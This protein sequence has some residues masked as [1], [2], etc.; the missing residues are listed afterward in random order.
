MSKKIMLSEDSLDAVNGG[1]NATSNGNVNVRAEPSLSAM[2]LATVPKGTAFNT[3]GRTAYA[4][5]YT[6]HEVTLATGSDPGWVAGNL[7][8]FF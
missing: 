7:L 1:A 2:I 3:T 8:N 4:D 5:G 6:W